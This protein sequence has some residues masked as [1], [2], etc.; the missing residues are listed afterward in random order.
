MLSGLLLFGHSETIEA[1]QTNKN[2]SAPAL[3]KHQATVIPRQDIL[4]QLRIRLEES[5]QNKAPEC[6]PYCA[7]I[8]SMK[9][10]IQNNVLHYSPARACNQ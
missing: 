6:L 5:E 3:E 1:K 7:H 2:T 9:L 10:T 8:E 4:D